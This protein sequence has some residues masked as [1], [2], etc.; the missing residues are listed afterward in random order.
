MESYRWILSPEQPPGN[1]GISN[2]QQKLAS[3]GFLLD[4]SLRD[5]AVEL[6][7]NVDDVPRTAS[8][9]PDVDPVRETAQTPLPR[10]GRHPS[11]PKN[12]ITVSQVREMRS[13]GMVLDEIA[14]HIGVSRRTFFRRWRELQGRDIDP[15]APFSTWGLERS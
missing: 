7:I 15:E 6:S 3:A 13:K 1:P 5:G 10:R 8:P 4:L 9:D 12:D 11:V 2:L 14:D